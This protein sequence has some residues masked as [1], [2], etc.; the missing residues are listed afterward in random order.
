MADANQLKRIEPIDYGED[1]PFAELTRIMGFDPRVPV[2]PTAAN[3]S[4]HAAV[5]PVAVEAA[6]AQDD[7]DFGIDLERELLGSLAFDDEP[8]VETPAATSP[9]VPADPEPL[10]A[11]DEEF[12]AAFAVEA[13]DLDL[14]LD[15]GDPANDDVAF[16]AAEPVSS[17]AAPAVTYADETVEDEPMAADRDY[18]EAFRAAGHDD[19][20]QAAV[21]VEPQAAQ[22]VAAEDD[23]DFSF[24]LAMAQVDMDFDASP[25][26]I[27]EDTRAVDEELD[28]PVF[29]EAAFDAALAIDADMIGVQGIEPSAAEPDAQ[30]ASYEEPPYE[31]PAYEA[32]AAEE[33]AVEAPAYEEPVARKPIF[34]VPPAPVEVAPLSEPASDTSLEDELTALLSSPIEHVDLPGSYESEPLPGSTAAEAR[35]AEVVED[36]GDAAEE[37]DF[38]DL[39]AAFADWHPGDA[40]AADDDDFAEEFAAPAEAY[41]EEA[42]A[43]EEADYGDEAEADAAYDDGQQQHAAYAD[44]AVEAEALEEDYAPEDYAPE[45]YAD[46]ADADEVDA[47]VDGEPSVAAAEEVAIDPFAALRAMAEAGRGSPAPFHAPYR[48]LA[49]PVASAAATGSSSY[50]YAA[51]QSGAP[52]RQPVEASY[53]APYE[54]ETQAAAYQPSAPVSAYEQEVADTYELEDY[55]AGA[56]EPEA[57]EAEEFVP[58]ALADSDVPDIETV[59]VP[60]ASIAVA[61]D[62]DLPELAFAVD[63]TTARVYDDFERD[64]AAAFAEPVPLDDVQAAEPQDLSAYG[65]DDFDTRP[66][67]LGPAAV[68]TAGAAGWSHAAKDGRFAD[69]DAELDAAANAAFADIGKFDEAFDEPA[70]A[71]LPLDEHRSDGA[72]RNLMIAAVVGGV[73]LLGG[74]GAFALSSGDGGSDA[75]VLVRAD[76]SPVKVRPENPGGTVVPNQDSKVYQTVTGGVSA[77]EQE[78]LI[79]SSEEPVAIDTV[80]G[81]L[82][83]NEDDIAVD[84]TGKIED[85][86]V[87]EDAAE[88]TPAAEEMAAVAPRKVRTMIVKPDGSLVP[89]EEPVAEPAIAEPKPGAEATAMQPAEAPAAAEPEVAAAEPVPASRVVETAPAAPVAEAPKPVTRTAAIPDAGPLAPSRPADQ[90]VDVVGEVKPEQVATAAAGAWSVQIASQ[91][92]E[93]AAKSTYQDLSR[94]YASVIGGKGVTIVKAEIAGKGTFYR[95]RVPASSRND[96]IALCEQYKAAGGN[97]FVSK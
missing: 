33:P 93:A 21:P 66:I 94:R 77:P 12:D 96:A 3:E 69:F 63:D 45:A 15:L 17:A 68:S 83:L 60:E 6:S 34:Q 13:S 27:A 25:E 57:G 82:P 85:R 5:P 20:A 1:D 23:L 35:A 41:A 28:L 8:A 46:E 65:Q 24:D 84:A 38:A 37:G 36:Y 88:T 18:D 90:P 53:E 29:D 42:P 26:A 70:A 75:P 72:R 95:V 4:G 2:R 50:G 7:V 31:E 30:E 47:V 71:P 48:S 9:Y 64:L 39:E 74:I 73:A 78:K 56:Y 87:P 11:L 49:T 32:A 62:L 58:A 51:A 61:D 91:P 79:T 22:A 52:A 10:P 80:E 86:V 16:D 55:E 76:D 59:D 92:T 67:D 43:A 97:C 89:R 44:D 54:A 40:I 81:A 14:D 19:L